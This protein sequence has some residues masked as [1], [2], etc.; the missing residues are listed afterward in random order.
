MENK[1]FVTGIPDFAAADKASLFRTRLFKAV[2]DFLQSTNIEQINITV[3]TNSEIRISGSP[4]SIAQSDTITSTAGLSTAVDPKEAEDKAAYIVANPLYDFEQ[5]IVPNAVEKNLITSIEAISVEEVVFDLWGMKKIQPNPR[6]VLN[7]YGPPGTG[8]TLAAHAVAKRMNKL[9][10][11]ASY[12]DIESKFHGEGPKNL[13]SI[14]R[15]AEKHNAVLFI[16]EADSLLSKRLVDVNSGSEQAINSMRSQLL[17]CLEQFKGV[18][19]F[20]TNLVEN[21]DKAFE[22]RIRNI[23]F[24]MPGSSERERIW[25]AH[26]LSTLPLEIIDYDCL[27]EIDEVCGRD[28]RE[29]VLDAAIRAALRAKSQGQHPNQGTISTNDLHDAILRKKNERVQPEIGNQ[30]NTDIKA[31]IEEQI[32]AISTRS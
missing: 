10:L 30:D 13:Q 25:R 2:S 19:I 8:K 18:V 7:F 26:L 31:K 22:T 1:L 12:A 5:L 32:K 28:I 9:I 23:K 21:Y 24:M 14:F 15:A 20:A 29:A 4:E 11:L 17:I 3:S 27:S 6:T 16:D